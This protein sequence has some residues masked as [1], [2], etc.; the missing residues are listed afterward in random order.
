[1]AS[2]VTELAG[3]HRILSPVHKAVSGHYLAD[4]DWATNAARGDGGKPAE[5]RYG[6]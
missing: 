6:G 4:L 3:L 5:A 2:A 1:V